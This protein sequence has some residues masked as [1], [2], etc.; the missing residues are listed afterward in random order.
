MKTT[1]NVFNVC[2]VGFAMGLR[3][4]LDGWKKREE[5]REIKRAKIEGREPEQTFHPL[6]LGA[7][8]VIGSILTLLQPLNILIITFPLFTRKTVKWDFKI[9]LKVAT[10][11][12]IVYLV[13]VLIFLAGELDSEVLGSVLI[14]F[15]YNLAISTL[16][17]YL[18]AFLVN[19]FDQAKR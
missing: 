15:I 17:L 11:I 2:M 3:K 9:C 1:D 13:T 12:S 8:V 14:G 16:I 10:M 4:S 6:M 19:F 7:F 5:K 18:G